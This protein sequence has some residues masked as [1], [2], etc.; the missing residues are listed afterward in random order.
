MKKLTIVHTICH[1]EW[2][3]MERRVYNESY[4]MHQ[5]GHTIIII[6]PKDTP[7]YK[8]A[9]EEKWQTIDI[10]FEKLSIIHDIYKLRLFLKKRKPDVLNTHG[11]MDTKIGL[12]AAWKLKIPSVI[13]S[14]HI[15]SP[16]QNSFHNRMLY[17]NM[18]KYIFT[19]ADCT[20]KQIIKDFH[21]TNDRIF[22]MPS[23]IVPPSCLPSHNEARKMLARELNV[24][25][26][27]KFIGFVGRISREK[28]IWYL[29]DAFIQIKDIMLDYHLVLIGE[30]QYISIFKERIQR[31]NLQDRIHIL[32]FKDNPWQYYR[33]FDCKSL[34][35]IENEGISQSLMEAMLVGCPVIGTNIGGI[36][37]IIK[38]QETGLLISP[39]NIKQLAN[40]IRQ[41]I[42]QPKKSE[43]MAHRATKFIKTH[44]TIDV[45]GDKILNVYKKDIISQSEF[46]MST[47]G[48]NILSSMNDINLS[49]SINVIDTTVIDTTVIDTTITD[50][51][52]RY[53]KAGYKLCSYVDKFITVENNT[54]PIVKHNLEK[55]DLLS[56]FYVRLGVNRNNYKVAPGLYGIG[57][58]DKN[59][60][61]LVTCNYKLTF[62]H[63]RKE[64][65]EK[66]TDNIKDK[67]GQINI[68]NAWI[69]VLDTNGINVWCAAGKGTFSTS[70]IVK[71]IQECSLEKVV[72][73]RQ[74]IVPQLGAISVSAI[75]VKKRSKFKVIYG[76]VRSKDIPTFLN[77]NKKADKSMRQVTFNLYERFILTPVE[78][79]I[80]L[81]ASAITA[82]ILFIVS[83]IGPDIFSFAD[84]WERGIFSSLTFIAGIFSGAFITPILLPYIPFKH[85]AT[86]G[87]IAGC[88]TSIFFMPYI[89]SNIDSIAGN[90]AIFLLLINTSS[91][92]AMNFTGTTPFTSPSGVEKEMKLF[93]PI[94]ATALIVS[95]ILWIYSAY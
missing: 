75:E 60:D 86:K 84:A 42:E 8:K 56:S 71:R 94:Q 93:I 48:I 79:I 87:I 65:I 15:T 25:E 11:N 3:G 53:E 14:R 78:I 76:P 54:I 12:F 82:I 28:G 5:K 88:F 13:L 90:I 63:L 59:S 26:T 95:F 49:S 68:I 24:D 36:P 6:A 29:I 46:K 7:I 18:C 44:H 17:Q 73:H 91:Y 72:T 52:A 37:D 67:N 35:S 1:G 70:E 39:E 16:V 80:A 77:N 43:H 62:D 66:K 10:S 83:G 34:G 19:T 22:T 74:I 21:I 23:G 47:S 2:G 92:F 40:A 9:F 41:I 57:T 89:L 69:L 20:T 38:H 4:W 31:E 64:L 45:M 61:V 27:S 33:A 55:E 32:G 85:F 51:N 50:T 30:G 81:K 58:P